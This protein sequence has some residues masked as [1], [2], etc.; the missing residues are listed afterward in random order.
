[1]FGKWISVIVIFWDEE[2]GILVIEGSVDRRS[3]SL[4]PRRCETRGQ[5]TGVT[6]I[7]KLKTKQ[8]LVVLCELL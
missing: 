4:K 2:Y 8:H 3:T 6:K 1:M 5:A 7:E